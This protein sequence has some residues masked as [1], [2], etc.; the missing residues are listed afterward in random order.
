MR[1]AVRRSLATGLLA[2]VLVGAGAGTAAAHVEVSAPG[3]VAGT[4]PLTVTFSAAAESSSSGIAGMRTQ[5]PEGIAPADVTLTSGPA[6]WTLTPTADG[7]DVGGPALPVGADLEYAV[8]VAQLPFAVTELA[9]PSIQRYADGSEDAW[10]ER[11]APGGPEPEQ[12]AP[13]ISVA[14]GAPAPATT[15]P[16]VPSPTPEAPAPTTDAAPATTPTAAASDD[17]GV[18]GGWLAGIGVLVLAATAAA[19]W[20]RR[21]RAGRG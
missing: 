18:S 21:S 19:V 17:G 2:A 20:F 16:A 5:L 11:P 6:G 15:A 9:F 3:A 13:V 14:P 1:V 12:P 4:G 8:T 10:I 7:Y